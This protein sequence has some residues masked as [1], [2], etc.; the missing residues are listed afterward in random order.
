MYTR[1]LEEINDFINQHIEALV[2]RFVGKI[3]VM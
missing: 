3:L 2:G 1:E